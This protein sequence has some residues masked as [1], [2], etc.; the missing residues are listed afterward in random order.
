MDIKPIE[1]YYNGY[2]FRSRLEARVAVFFDALGVEYE[3]EP[4]G[5][6]L[7]SGKRYLPDFRVKCYGTR[8]DICPKSFDLWIE[9]KGRMT[10]EDADKIREFNGMSFGPNGAP[11]ETN[12]RIRPV[13][14]IN[15]IPGENESRDG[16][17][18]LHVY[19]PMDGIEIYPFNYAL[20]DG[21]N[22]GAYP[23]ADSYGCFYLW[24][25]D[26]NYINREDVDRVEKAWTKARQARFEYGET[27][28]IKSRG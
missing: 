23:A 28:I 5:F 7:E 18:G 19:E 6:L 9:V 14:I 3:Y 25:D 11:E 16:G 22:F 21:D 20:I 26:S 12:N 1:T 13:L 10:Q 4:E 24:G 8:G 27:P 2:K 17:Y 15:K